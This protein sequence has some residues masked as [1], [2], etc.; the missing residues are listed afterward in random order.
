[1]LLEAETYNLLFYFTGLLLGSTAP[2]SS[3]W[4]TS[5]DSPNTLAEN[6]SPLL[7]N[8]VLLSR[9]L[10]QFIAVALSDITTYLI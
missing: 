3:L 9:L 1:M 4:A 2:N 8:P 10:N 5:Q 7:H 6:F